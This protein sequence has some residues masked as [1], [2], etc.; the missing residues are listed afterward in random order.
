MT[1]L[2]TLTPEEIDGS[3]DRTIQLPMRGET[4]TLK[5]LPYLLNMALPNFYFHVTTAY[6]ILRHNGISIGKQDYIGGR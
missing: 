1:V 4:L 3:D 6:C 2:G 5:G